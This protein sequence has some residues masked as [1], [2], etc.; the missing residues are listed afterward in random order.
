MWNEESGV[1]EEGPTRRTIYDIYPWTRLR[2]RNPEQVKV[3]FFFVC[4]VFFADVEIPID[5]ARCVQRRPVISVLRPAID[6]REGK[7][8]VERTVAR[9]ARRVYMYAFTHI[10]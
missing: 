3:G 6:A 7:I 9:D 10:E 4:N 2:D 1:R 5:L 8:Y